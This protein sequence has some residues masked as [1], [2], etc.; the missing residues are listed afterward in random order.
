MIEIWKNFLNHFA[1]KN[2]DKIRLLS[3]YMII[4]FISIYLFVHG[5]LILGIYFLFMYFIIIPYFYYI[6]NKYFIN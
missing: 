4:I 5:M 1:V 6:L 2:S 3:L